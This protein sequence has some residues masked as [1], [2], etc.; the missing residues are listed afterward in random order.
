M[1]RWFWVPGETWSP[2]TVA[3]RFGGGF[4]GWAP[5]PPESEL[6]DQDNAIL[7]SAWIFVFASE[8]QD[9]RLT[10][11]ALPSTMTAT[12]FARTS[13]PL[14]PQAALGP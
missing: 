13:P 12:A 6:A 5:L 10:V 8:F 1:E 9:V 3:W 14:S 2:A 4:I 7:E 11:A